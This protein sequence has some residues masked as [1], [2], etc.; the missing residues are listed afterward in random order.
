MAV[1]KACSKSVDGGFGRSIMSKK[2]KSTARISI[3]SSK[4]KVLSFPWRKWSM[5]LEN[6]PLQLRKAAEDSCVSGSPTWRP[7]EATVQR[8]ESEAWISMETP[9]VGDAT[10][11]RHL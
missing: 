1:N 9:N 3:Y 5:E 8:C 4:D 7:R 11:M 2:G 10:V 6:L